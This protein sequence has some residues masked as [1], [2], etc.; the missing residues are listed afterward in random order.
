MRRIL[1]T[2]TLF[3]FYIVSLFI[4][5]KDSNISVLMYHSVENSGWKYSVKIKDFKRQLEYLVNNFKI[6]FLEEIVL[7][8]KEGKGNN[9]SVALTFDDGYED[10]YKTVFPLVK[11]YNIPITVFLTTNLEKKKTL[12][13]LPRLTWEQCKEMHESG[14]VKF[15]VHGR[16]HLNL[17]TIDYLHN[18]IIGSRDDIKNNL[19]YDSKYIA[20]ASGYKNET[21]VDFVKKN[22]FQAGFSINE[23]LIKHGDDLF[24][25]K[26]TQVDGTMSFSLFKMRLT[27]AVD[28]NR[29]FV[30]T[31]RYGR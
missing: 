6:I 13:N 19:G 21:V 28:L 24:S 30:N 10:T 5:E 17:K 27:K 20:Y 1:K 26:R 7:Y 3:F 29:R 2:S 23:G 12:G 9:K 22:N 15:E 25:V 4:K 31:I 18:E 8:I 16:E 14:L 11:E